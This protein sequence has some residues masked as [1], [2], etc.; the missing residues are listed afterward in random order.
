MSS[1]NFD[2]SPRRFNPIWLVAGLLSGRALGY[3]AGMNFGFWFFATTSSLIFWQ[4]TG[5]IF[6]AL[7]FSFVMTSEV[8]RQVKYAV[9]GFGIGSALAEKGTIAD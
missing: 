9:V 7:L 6:I 3:V 1:I 2:I 4:I 5:A 8:P